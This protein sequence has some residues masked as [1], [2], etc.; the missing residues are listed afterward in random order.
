MELIYRV[1]KPETIARFIHENNI[2]LQLIKKEE[3]HYQIFVNKVH[4]KRSD[5][6]KKGDKIHFLI[7]EEG[8]DKRIKPE[9]LK[10]NIV[11]ED[12]YLLVVNKPSQMQ[13]MISKAHLTGTLANGI[14][15]Y[16][17]EKGIKSKMHFITKLDKEASG[18]IVVAKH[19][20][21]KYLLSKKLENEVIY[22]FKAIVEGIL[23]LKENEIPLPISRL[24]GSV[25]R[26]VSE[27]G[28]ECLTQY[29]VTKEFDKYSLLKVTV[30]N[31][32]AHQIR[33]HFAF[34]GFPIVG[35]EIYNKTKHGVDE[36][37][38]FC[39]RVKFIHP[40]T[41]KTMDLELELPESFK[42][43]INGTKR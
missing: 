18:L 9:P 35:D 16:Y 19:K 33:V 13:M 42:E 25:I 8:Y 1:K 43:F 20:F 37:L 14:S 34:F 39:D 10:L 30:K 2:P 31:K 11:Y 21:I 22:Q 40:I 17:L 15:N 28:D 27:K 3:K 32:K 23:E 29:K 24:E 41:E 38:L 5:T 26:E 6:V 7:I 4:K 12:E 36:I